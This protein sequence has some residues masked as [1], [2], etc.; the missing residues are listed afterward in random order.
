MQL[1][2]L[3]ILSNLEQNYLLNQLKIMIKT[4]GHPI[5]D[6]INNTVEVEATVV[7]VVVTATA[8][9][10]IPITKRIIDTVLA[11]VRNLHQEINALYAVNMG[12]GLLN[13]RKAMGL[14]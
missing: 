7:A 5:F 13:A 3:T 10:E 4:K 11:S 14:E 9:K 6:D 8:G 2:N 1:K 12:I